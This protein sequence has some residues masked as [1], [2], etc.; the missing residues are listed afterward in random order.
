MGSGTGFLFEEPYGQMGDPGE[1]ASIVEARVYVLSD[2]KK[3]M[4]ARKK[5]CTQK[6]ARTPSFI[7]CSNA[8]HVFESTNILSLIQA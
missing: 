4:H 5:A 7:K 3:S 1:R 6:H 2:L 8:Q